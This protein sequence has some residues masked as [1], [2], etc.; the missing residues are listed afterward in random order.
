M[1]CKC[2]CW[3]AMPLFIFRVKSLP[4]FSFLCTLPSLFTATA[5]IFSV[6]FEFYFC[7]YSCTLVCCCSPSR[8]LS[9]YSLPTHNLCC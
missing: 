9:K 6:S 1:Y 8:P 7:F 2:V 5:F 4:L 3:L